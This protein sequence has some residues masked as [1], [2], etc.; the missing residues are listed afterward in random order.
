MLTCENII[1]LMNFD[2]HN[3]PVQKY[4][5]MRKTTKKLL[6]DSEKSNEF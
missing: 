2:Y 5:A 3:L 6:F 1:D 4:N